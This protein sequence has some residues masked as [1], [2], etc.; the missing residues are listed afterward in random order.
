MP[1]SKAFGFTILE[2]LITITITSIL[3]L[4]TIPDMRAFMINNRSTT[5]EAINHKIKVK[6]CKSLDHKT[7][8]GNWENG[9]IVINENEK[10]LRTFAALND[11]DTLIW[12][13]SLGRDEFVEFTSDGCTNGQVGTFTYI[14]KGQKEHSKK[15]IINQTG[16]I[17]VDNGVVE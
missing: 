8:S 9:Q 5:S 10:L 13:S 11:R 16:R 1:L 4:L 14:P 3:L 17:R 12:N 7:C 2:L 6:Y 15:I